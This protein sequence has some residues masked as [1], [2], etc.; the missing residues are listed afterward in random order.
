MKEGE[1]A[2]L[3]LF[4]L[5]RSHRRAHSVNFIVSEW[6]LSFTLVQFV[7]FPHKATMCIAVANLDT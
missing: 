2:T 3:Q 5:L 6:L 4:P 1:V 7:L